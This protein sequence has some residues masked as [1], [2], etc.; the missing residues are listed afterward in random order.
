VV[1]K[2]NP[3][4]DDAHE[5]ISD[6]E[7]GGLNLGWSERRLKKFLFDFVADEVKCMIRALELRPLHED[8]TTIPRSRLACAEL[9]WYDVKCDRP[10]TERK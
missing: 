10:V 6:Y 3:A 2:F 1:R 9:D 8:R 7:R 4:S 5:W